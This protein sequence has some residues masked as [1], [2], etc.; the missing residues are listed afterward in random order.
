[1]ELP[2]TILHDAVLNSS[3]E[4]TIAA[5][6]SIHVSDI[7]ARGKYGRTALHVAAKIGNV[8][9]I[10]LLLEHGA[11]IKIKNSHGFTALYVAAVAN[12]I[13]AMH[14]LFE[15]PS[16]AV[17]DIDSPDLGGMSPLIAACCNNCYPE[18][19]LCLLKNGADKY[20]KDN[21]NRTA[22]DWCMAKGFQNLFAIISEWPR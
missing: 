18:T 21:I 14:A 11:D 15:D 10:K 22:A 13:D 5:I 17:M 20:K 7:N 3:M 6:S 9:I 4:D 2:N 19:V 8:P 12:N 1:M 16:G